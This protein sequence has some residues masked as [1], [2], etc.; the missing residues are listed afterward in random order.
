MR[1]KEHIMSMLLRTRSVPR[2]VNRR[3]DDRSGLGIHS[4]S[5]LPPT[6][7]VHDRDHLVDR[8]TGTGCHGINNECIMSDLKEQSI[9]IDNSDPKRMAS[10]IVTSC[11][12]G[13]RLR[14]AS[15][16]D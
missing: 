1:L 13:P 2:K 10:A 9:E 16:K 6:F 14:W 7:L 3:A 11:L 4:R 8:N 15:V 12:W 5:Q